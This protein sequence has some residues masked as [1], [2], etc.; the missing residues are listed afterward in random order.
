MKRRASPEEAAFRTVLTHALLETLNMQG[1]AETSLRR[2][3]C[4]ILTLGIIN[5][6]ILAII[7]GSIVTRPTSGDTRGS[8]SLAFS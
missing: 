6:D 8:A 1:P 5:G 7:A 4:A 2:L 3:S